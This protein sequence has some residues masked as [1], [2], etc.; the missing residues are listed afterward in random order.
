MVLWREQAEQDLAPAV[1]FALFLTAHRI[2][3]QQR[4]DESMGWARD[5]Q[6][7]V[8]ADLDLGA[9]YEI[10]DKDRLVVPDQCRVPKVDPSPMRLSTSSAFA[11]AGT[12]GSGSSS[13]A[14][15]PVGSI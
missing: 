4:V 12:S 13:S 11:A 15:T 10:S 5:V 8:G 2:V 6:P 3:P 14:T 1:P 7:K 9:G